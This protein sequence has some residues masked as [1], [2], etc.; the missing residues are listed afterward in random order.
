MDEKV[1][2]EKQVKEI[3][4]RAMYEKDDET[5]YDWS[6]ELH[7]DDVYNGWNQAT[8]FIREQFGIKL[9]EDEVLEIAMDLDL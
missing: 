3:I 8:N 2:T 6:D 7:I 5:Y 9:D 4:V 1:F